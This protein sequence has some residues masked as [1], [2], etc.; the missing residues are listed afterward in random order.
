MY[1]NVYACMT[2]MIAV[3]E[4]DSDTINNH[5]SF[6]ESRRCEQGERWRVARQAEKDALAER[7][8]RLLC[9]TSSGVTS[10][11]TKWVYTIKSDGRYNW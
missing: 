6:A 5:K 4:H 2:S 3:S 8:V 9:K 10:I 1:T 11:P 7:G